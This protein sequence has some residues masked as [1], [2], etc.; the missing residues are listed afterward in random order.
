MKK[1]FKDALKESLSKPISEETKRRRTV[2]TFAVLSALG[3]LALV[4]VTWF[5][6]RSHALGALI[7]LMAG[8][9]LSLAVEA[10]EGT[11]KFFPRKRREVPEAK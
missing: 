8:G 3:F 6:E 10:H 1:S 11:L 7:L 9:Y 2:V 5:P 4:V